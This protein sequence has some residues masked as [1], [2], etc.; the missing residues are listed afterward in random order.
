MSDRNKALVPRGAEGCNCVR[1]WLA[2]E[3]RYETYWY[4]YRGKGAPRLPGKPGSPEFIA[5]RDWARASRFVGAKEPIKTAEPGP[6]TLA[7]LIEKFLKS[8]HFNRFDE[9]TKYHYGWVVPSIKNQFGDL[10]LEA[11]KEKRTRAIVIEWRDS[12]ADGTCKTLV[13]R[14]GDGR[15]RCASTSMADL[16]LQK[17]AAILAWAVKQG[18]IDANPCTLVERL[19][20]G[21]R[22]DK[23]WT[24]EQEATF[25]AEAR[26]DL[27]EA[28][29]E[30]VWTGFR[31]GDCVDVRV[32]EYD[33]K[34]IRRE[35]EKRP[36]PGKPRKRVT[37]P[38]GGPFKPIFDA[39]VMRTGVADAD[40]ETRAKTKVLR[41]SEGHPWANE[42]AL[43][44]AFHRECIRLGIEDRTFH[45]LRRTAVV[46][47]AVAGCTE[48]EIASITAHSI[49][50]VKSILEKHYLYLDPQLATNAIRKLE[51]S[52]HHQYAVFVREFLEIRLRESRIVTQPSPT[53]LPNATKRSLIVPRKR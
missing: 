35:L 21:S 30:A 27:V 19:H 17:L 50:D 5:A 14:R 1:K 16:H 51:S 38:V 23:V 46:R 33:G 20:E 11:L 15:P 36:R 45:D 37:I 40:L 22:L 24:W 12:I 31:G 42:R 32:S 2:K 44:S 7:W 41:N 29:L 6:D 13:S 53:E 34:F 25:I 47:L 52:T 10:P 49:N 4:P 39:M 28:Y 26:P 3:G 48:P 8:Q 18:W 9:R 43:Y